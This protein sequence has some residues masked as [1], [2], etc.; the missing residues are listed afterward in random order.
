MPG[1]NGNIGVPY[2]LGPKGDELVFTLEKADFANRMILA[3]RS[4][5]AAPG[6]RLV[7]L[8]YAVQ[9]P[10]S[11]DRIFFNQ[12]FGFTVV[13]P[14]DKNF[15]FDGG[16]GRGAAAYHP[17]KRESMNIMLKPAQKVRAVAVVA[18]HPTGPINKLIVQRNKATPVLRYDL[19]EKVGKQVG[20]FAA[21]NGIDSLTTGKGELTVPFE[22]GDWD[23]T[24]EKMES[25]PELQGFENLGTAQK[26]TVLTIQIVNVG[27][28]P[29][30]MHQSLIMPKMKDEDGSDIAY[31]GMY[32]NSAPESFNTGG[33]ESG[34]TARFRMV[35]KSSLATIP[36]K[37][38]L[39]EY[40]SG[41][42]I[43]VSLKKP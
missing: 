6:E 15:V 20:A 35:F 17:Q 7:L 42:T 5:F 19:K 37:V 10:A 25:G 18:I 13:S 29:A 38:D 31:S 36:A 43:S 14:D 2:Q 11:K 40:W 32:K 22:L 34:G 3:D 21:P 30:P 41:R 24:V 12:S 8:T 9:N 16:S 23:V 28:R 1:D 26:Y 27:F 33:V 4:V 39:T